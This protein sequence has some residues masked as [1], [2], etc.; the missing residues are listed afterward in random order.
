MKLKKAI[1]KLEPLVNRKFKNIF[2]EEQMKDIIINKGK[3]GQL[4]E[5]ALGLDN[6]SRKLDFEDGELKTN[7]CNS[8]GKPLETMYITQISRII[9]DLL[10]E[11]DFY[12]S[13][14][15]QKINN[16]LYVP[17]SKVGNPED[18]MFLPFTHI[19]LENDEF[20]NLEKEEFEFLK[21]QLE[22]DYYTICRKLKTHVEN[23]ED[24]F[25][26]TSNGQF[27]Q[28]RSKDSKPYHPIYSNIYNKEVSNKN[29][30]FYFKK[31]FMM[32]INDY[33]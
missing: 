32:F 25:I 18:W 2:S 7:K 6:S 5:L 20:I 19:N 16:L 13:R 17:I 28:I 27:I 11:K 29:H 23:S 9:D 26:H 30:A 8:D 14:L 33:E 4:L 21:N 15:Y 1:N 10:K 31:Q 3:S 12:S 22:T 24:G